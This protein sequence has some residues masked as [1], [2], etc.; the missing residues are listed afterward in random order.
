MSV[1][2][3]A[4]LSY[5][6]LD[7]SIGAGDTTLTVASAAPFSTVAQFRINIDNELMLVTGVAGAVFTVTRGVEGT[8]AAAHAG[9]AKVTQTITAAGLLAIFSPPTFVFQPGGTAAGNVYTSWAALMAQLNL[10][11]PAGADSVRPPS[12]I[13]VDDNYTTPAVIPSG[14]YNL[15]NVEFA[16]CA[17]WATNTGDSFLTFASGVTITGGTAGGTLLFTR[18]LTASFAGT[19]TCITGSGTQQW[20]IILREDATLKSATTGLF[21]DVASGGFGVVDVADGSVLGDGT[22]ATINGASGAIYVHAYGNG[23]IAAGAVTGSGGNVYWDT[24]IPGAQGAGVTVTNTN[25]YSPATAGNWA[26]APTT[27][28]GA[29]DVLAARVGPLCYAAASSLTTQ[30]QQSIPA[31]SGALTSSSDLVMGQIMPRAGTLTT[32]RVRH[33]GAAGNVGGQT[34]TYQVF[35]NGS[36]IGTSITGVATTAGN[37]TG[38]VTFTA[39][40]FV[41]GDIITV[42]LLPSGVLTTA[43]TDV[44]AGV[45]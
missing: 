6:T 14:A 1:E 22:H 17:N 26:S 25:G 37:K 5:S 10:I 33:T 21:L 7:A 36:G 28:N 39:V 13:V 18:G 29:L 31:G 23:S 34:I 44:M 24:N 12:L 3:L 40:A 8:A 27:Q 38:N 4:N 20:H 19:A 11:C 32:L 43:L 45:S 2:Q 9:G 16:G 35:K 42:Q 30:V 15:S 41:A